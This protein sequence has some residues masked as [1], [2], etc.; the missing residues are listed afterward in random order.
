MSIY[1][2]CATE[3]ATVTD[4]ILVQ[5]VVQVPTAYLDPN[6]AVLCDTHTQTFTA[7]TMYGGSSP[8]FT[9]YKNGNP[10]G[11]NSATYTDANLNAGDNIR[12]EMQSDNPCAQPITASSNQLFITIAGP[13][14]AQIS[15]TPPAYICA[16]GN[17]S[18]YCY[19]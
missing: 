18:I 12:C 2:E 14:T 17:A 1:P 11:S 10:V 8:I 13:D 4:S 5:M 9:W 16:G 15:I 19:K 7:Q 6:L 3:M